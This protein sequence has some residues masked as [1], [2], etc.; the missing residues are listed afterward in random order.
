MSALVALTGPYALEGLC[1]KR[2]FQRL[3][4]DE[5][6]ALAISTPESLG[7]WLVKR[8]LERNFITRQPSESH[9]VTA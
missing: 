7:L 3:R 2:T 8:L 6:N 1:F 4:I 5:P 9:P